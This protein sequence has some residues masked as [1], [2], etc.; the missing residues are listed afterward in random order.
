MKGV[1]SNTRYVILKIAISPGTVAHTFNL[2]IWEAKAGI[3]C[4]FPACQGYIVK[5]CLKKK[6]LPPHQKLPEKRENG[7]L[8]NSKEGRV[9]SIA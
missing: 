5:P 4:E 8:V 9:C 7:K 6:D 3:S 2:G 1:G